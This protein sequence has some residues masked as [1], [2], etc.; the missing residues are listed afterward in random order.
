VAKY[1]EYPFLRKVV[2]IFT[3]FWCIA[4]AG[5][6]WSMHRS[7]NTRPGFFL[8]LAGIPIAIAWGLARAHIYAL[9][10]TSDAELEKAIKA[11][12]RKRRK[13]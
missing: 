10:I 4:C 3:V 1:N 5:M 8:L 7:P 12:N 2:I 9:S 13:K 6:Y 11:K